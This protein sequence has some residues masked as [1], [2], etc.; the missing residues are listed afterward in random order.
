MITLGQVLDNQKNFVNLSYRDFMLRIVRPHTSFLSH[1]CGYVILPKG[2]KLEGK[3]YDDIN[4]DV[5][6]GLTFSD[7][8]VVFNY[9]GEKLK[10]EKHWMIGFD[11]AHSYDISTIH[12]YNYLK[13]EVLADSF[14]DEGNVLEYIFAADD[15]TDHRPSYKTFYYVKRELEKLVDQ[16]IR[17]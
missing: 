12:E 15:K 3:H 9:T 14:D 1:Y 8:T 13:R 17:M 5:H 7:E 11:C 16:I 4:V 2:H 6:G 10:E